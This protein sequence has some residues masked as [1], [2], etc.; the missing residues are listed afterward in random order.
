MVIR[1]VLV[2][3]FFCLAPAPA[4]SQLPIPLAIEARLGYA[5]PTWGASGDEIAA[6]PE[7]GPSFAIGGRLE[8]TRT[9]AVFAAYH[10]TR[11]GCGGCSAR[12]LDDSMVLEGVEGGLRLGL[13]QQFGF[14]PWLQGGALYQTLAFSG[15]GERMTS[16]LGF[17]FTAAG[18]VTIPLTGRLEISPG[19]RYLL[20]PASFGFSFAPDLSVDASAVALDVGLAF[21]L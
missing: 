17:G 19:V 15:D 6:E 5:I 20:V 9:V 3:V 4:V 12:E 13:G 8:A 7:A 16:A 1:S 14:A 2:V 18:G 10:Q 11:F 21:R